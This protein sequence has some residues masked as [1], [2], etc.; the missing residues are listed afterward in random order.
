MTD[1]T[2]TRVSLE[3]LDSIEDR[4]RYDA[5]EGPSLGAAFWRTASVV[6]PEGPKEYLTVRL[7]NDRAGVL[8]T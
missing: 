8:R 4:T 2:A 3:D 7:D 5:P 6:Y 1:S